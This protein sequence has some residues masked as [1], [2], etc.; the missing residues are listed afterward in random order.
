MISSMSSLLQWIADKLVSEMR[1]T[2]LGSEQSF[3]IG[4]HFE[5]KNLLKSLAFSLKS[6]ASLLP[7]FSSGINGVFYH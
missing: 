5:A 3:V 1:T 6:A 7:T 4:V 2:G